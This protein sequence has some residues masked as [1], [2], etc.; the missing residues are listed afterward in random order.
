M[1]RWYFESGLSWAGIPFLGPACDNLN[2]GNLPLRFLYP[3]EEQSLNAASYREAV[4]RLGGSNSQ[5]AA[6]WLVQ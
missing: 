2:D 3:G 1:R 5:N 4:G 6:M